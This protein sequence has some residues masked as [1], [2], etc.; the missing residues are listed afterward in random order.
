MSKNICVSTGSA[1]SSAKSA[2][3][4][5]LLALGI[6]PELAQGAIR[7]S[8]SKWTTRDEMDFVA[9]NLIEIVKKERN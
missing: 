3:S 2:P 8:L 1:C 9:E 5:V 4:H 7:I 6:D